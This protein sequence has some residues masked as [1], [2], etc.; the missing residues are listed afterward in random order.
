M[1]K[2]LLVALLVG[3]AASCADAQVVKSSRWLNGLNKRYTATLDLVYNTV[4]TVSDRLDVYV[5]KD[6]PTPAPVLIWIHGG[7]WGRLSKDSSVGQVIPYLELG[8]VVINTNYRLTPAALA[9]AAVQDCRAVLRWIAANEKRLHADLKRIVVSGSS[10]GGHLALMTGMLPDGIAF[11]TLGSIGKTPRVAAIVNH[12]GITDVNDLLGGENRKGYAVNWI[13]EQ[14]DREQ[15]AKAVSPLTYVRKGLPPIFSV[16]GDADPT[17]P[18]S[19]SVRLHK[20][21]NELGVPNEFVT[22]PGG[23]HGKFSKEENDMIWKNIQTF[24]T[25][26]G[27]LGSD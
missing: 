26:N 7:G 9:P 23:K 16:Q 13:G 17:V 24:L 1:K 6:A 18:Y 10:A 11:D 2:T 14:P 15:I 8:W 12:Y 25:K 5:P 4:D 3:Y 27:I 20:A 19:H 21:L 22:I